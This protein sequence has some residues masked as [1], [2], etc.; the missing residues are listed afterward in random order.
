[1]T[2]PDLPPTLVSTRDDLHQLAF[3]ALSPARHKA[4]GRMGL[5]A[6]PGGFGTPEFD[7]SVARVDGD[8]LVHKQD[9]NVATQTITTIRTAAEFFGNGYQVEWFAD[10]HDPLTPADPDAP[11]SVDHEASHA[12]G[13]WFEFGFGVLN[14]LRTHGND[15]DDVSEAQ[16]WPEHF[17][18]ATEL[19]SQDNGQRAS[20]GASPGDGA[21]PE[22]YIYV[23]A[24][25]EIDR[26]DTFWNEQNF[27]GA[28]LG[29]QQLR[30]SEDPKSRALDFLLEGYR[31]LH[32]G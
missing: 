2:L 27:N 10:F 19:G 16:L 14:E 15:R 8:L 5:R 31:I 17:D 22:P 28:S 6:T 30:S 21:H 9:G 23:A 18:P 4:V 13:T 11:L 25:G 1:M 29:Y 7:G 12:I 3:F 20:F 24:W 26:S 32:A